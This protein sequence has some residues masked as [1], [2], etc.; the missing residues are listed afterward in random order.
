MD[1]KD[2]KN[3]GVVMESNIDTF[4]ENLDE[5]QICAICVD[6]IEEEVKTDCNHSFCKTC[7]TQY[8]YH[9]LDNIAEFKAD[10]KCPLCRRYLAVWKLAL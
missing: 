3:K 9:I 4:E 6:K 10:F 5:I 8:I 1:L 2:N 7:M